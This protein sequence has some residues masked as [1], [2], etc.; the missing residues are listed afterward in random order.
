MHLGIADCK[1][2]T[3]SNAAVQVDVQIIWQ[4]TYQDSKIIHLDT[5]FRSNKVL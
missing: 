3:G 5:C 2:A 4:T 1:P